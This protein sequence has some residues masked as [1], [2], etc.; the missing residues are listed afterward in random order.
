MSHLVHFINAI[1][2][3]SLRQAESR[4]YRFIIIIIDFRMRI[5]ETCTYHYDSEVMSLR[6]VAI[7]EITLRPKHAHAFQIERNVQ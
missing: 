6:P 1:T 7:I 4:L 2:S 5:V 3:F